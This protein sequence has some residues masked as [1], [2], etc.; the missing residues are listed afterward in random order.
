MNEQNKGN[1]PSEDQIKMIKKVASH[2]AKGFE[3]A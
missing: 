1:K 3:E 2:V